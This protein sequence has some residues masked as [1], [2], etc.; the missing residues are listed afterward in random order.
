MP[1][2]LGKTILFGISNIAVSWG[3]WAIG[4]IDGS[5]ARA[6]FLFATFGFG[7]GAYEMSKTESGE[8][9]A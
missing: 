3:L 7:Y 1:E 4:E 5:T 9:A 6:A 2:W 8:E